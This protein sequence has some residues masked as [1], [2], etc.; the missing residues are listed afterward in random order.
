MYFTYTYLVAVPWREGQAS[1][2]IVIQ[3]DLR[4]YAGVD[5]LCVSFFFLLRLAGD[6]I[7]IEKEIER[8]LIH[9]RDR[10]R[11]VGKEGSYM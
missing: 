6:S 2:L 5:R 9:M 1:F 11:D 3:I 7:L 8:D 10:G 4:E